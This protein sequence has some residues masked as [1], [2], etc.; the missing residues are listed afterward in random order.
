[1]AT[2]TFNSVAGPVNIGSGYLN[3]CVV[4]YTGDTHKVFIQVH[5]VAS[6]SGGETPVI[7]R[8]SLRSEGPTE[9]VTTVTNYSTGIVVALSSTELTYTALGSGT[10]SIVRD[11]RP[12]PASAV[13]PFPA[14]LNVEANTVGLYTYNGT[15]LIDAMENDTFTPTATIIS[16]VSNVAGVLAMDTTADE[17]VVGT[18][19]NPEVGGLIGSTEVTCE[20]VCKLDT[21]AGD[22]VLIYVGTPASVNAAFYLFVDNAGSDDL[23]YGHEHTSQTK[24][25]VNTGYVLTLGEW[26]HIAFTRSSAASPIVKVYINGNLWTTS[27]ALTT[28]DGGLTQAVGVAGNSGTANGHVDVTVAALGSIGNDWDLDVVAGTGISSALAAAADSVLKTI[29]VTLATDG[30]GDPDAA[31][32]TAT[33]VTAALDALDECAAVVDGTGAVAVAVSADDFAGGTHPIVNVGNELDDGTANWHG[34]IRDVRISSVVK[35]AAQ[36]LEDAKQA[37][38]A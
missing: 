27:G 32:N 15:T 8:G 22:P 10:I 18:V 5:N 34:Q 37:L 11:V 17:Y 19:S 9:L 6:L 4:N 12:E 23:A 36:L 1:M 25:E 7:T 33:L 20:V 24:V 14:P 30:A 2:Q 29:T 13:V 26:Y 38:G 35:T 31:A 28:G 21:L 16:N 3:S